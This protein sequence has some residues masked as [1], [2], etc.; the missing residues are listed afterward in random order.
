M[1]PEE[2]QFL[3]GHG[4]DLAIY[5]YYLGRTSNFVQ[6][7]GVSVSRTKSDLPSRR[8]PSTP[9]LAPF[10]QSARALAAANAEPELV[11]ARELAWQELPESPDVSFGDRLRAAVGARKTVEISRPR[12]VD[13]D[14]NAI[15]LDEHDAAF[16][17]VPV[18]GQVYVHVF[19]LEDGAGEVLLCAPDANPTKRRLKPETRARRALKQLASRDTSVPCQLPPKKPSRNRRATTPTLRPLARQQAG[20]PDRSDK[21]LFRAIFN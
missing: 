20:R 16:V 2:Q 10:T 7:V 13:V 11:T 9:V 5:F 17:L 12:P 14:G 18:L 15:Y 6:C 19:R 8:V 3:R 4:H 21:D 1:C